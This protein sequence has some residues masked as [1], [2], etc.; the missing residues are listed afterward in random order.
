MYISSLKGKHILVTAGPTWAPIDKVRVITNIF[1]GKTGCSIA[2]CAR[3]QGAKVKLLLGPGRINLPKDYFKG[4]SVTRFKYFDELLMLTRAEVGSRKYDAIIHSAAISD[5]TPLKIA[6]NKIPSGK[7]ELIIR[8]K[9]TVKIIKYIKKWVPK[10]IVAQ[11]K[12]EVGKTKK[13]LIKIANISMS[14]KDRKSVV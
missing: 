14:K 1:S 9:P 10:I 12:L 4:I 3:K 5:Y 2:H 8:F 11:F 7:K 6:N 13:K